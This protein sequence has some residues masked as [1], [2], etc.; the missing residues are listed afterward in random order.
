MV[1]AEAPLSG[2]QYQQEFKPPPDGSATGIQK[3]EKVVPVEDEAHDM[4][5]LQHR[6]TAF[7]DAWPKLEKWFTK[8]GTLQKV[9]AEEVQE[10]VYLEVEKILE[11][12]LNRV[13]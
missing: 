8:F 1:F 13:R 2:E 4:E 12:T 10:T 11:D 5:Q 7:Q 3:Q 9:N 6:L